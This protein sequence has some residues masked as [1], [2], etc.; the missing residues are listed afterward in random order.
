MY[1]YFQKWYNNVTVILRQKGAELATIDTV[2][3]RMDGERLRELREE[4]FLSHRELA[5][6]AGVSPTTVLSLE[7]NEAE[8]QR[9]TIRKLAKALGVDPHEL[10]RQEG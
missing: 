3:P 6:A 5:K 10:V 7:R 2:M 1:N 8:P 9:R 4:L